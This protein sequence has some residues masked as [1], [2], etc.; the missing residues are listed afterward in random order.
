[1]LVLDAFPQDGTHKKRPKW[2]TP[3]IY[4]YKRCFI[5][6]R[7]LRDMKSLQKNSKKKKALQETH[8]RIILQRLCYVQN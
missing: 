6:I 7:F 2:N 4:A 8:L 5:T 1:M 3:H